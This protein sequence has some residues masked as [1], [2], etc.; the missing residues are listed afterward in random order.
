MTV[1]NLGEGLTGRERGPLERS[2]STPAPVGRSSDPGGGDGYAVGGMVDGVR[3]YDP[4]WPWGI[5]PAFQWPY[6]L[7]GDDG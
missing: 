6:P 1:C 5:A 4:G 2:A 3:P 7:D